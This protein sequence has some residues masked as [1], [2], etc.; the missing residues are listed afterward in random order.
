MRKLIESN[1]I[2]R[3]RRSSPW[4][5]PMTFGALVLL[6]L[7]VAIPGV[8]QNALNQQ[9]AH[10]GAQPSSRFLSGWVPIAGDSEGRMVAGEI[11][12]RRTTGLSKTVGGFG[13]RPES[14]HETKAPPTRRIFSTYSDFYEGRGM[15]NG[16]KY[17]AKE[18]TCASND[19][20]LGTKLRL[21]VGRHHLSPV[22][23]TDRMARRFSGVRID[24]SRG[25]WNRLTTNAPPGLVR[26]TVQIR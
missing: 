13:E 22:I 7:T 11:P 16:H 3:P 24:L 2:Y 6:F 23:V 1:A 12:A 20:P 21:T 25:A 26:G 14:A 9:S 10:D 5:A 8:V 19:W 18:W 15:A 17:R 4:A